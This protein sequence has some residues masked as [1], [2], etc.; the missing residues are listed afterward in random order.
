MGI[1]YGCGF[2]K[3]YLPKNQS[4]NLFDKLDGFFSYTLTKETLNKISFSNRYP[5]WKKHANRVTV[6]FVIREQ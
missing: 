4:L 2:G 6:P 1:R 3:P 5:S